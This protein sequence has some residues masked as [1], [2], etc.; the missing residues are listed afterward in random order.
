MNTD[1]NQPSILT[2]RLGQSD[3][4][5]QVRSN[6]GVSVSCLLT[7]LATAATIDTILDISQR[8][9]RWPEAC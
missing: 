4:A 6:L 8:M 3:Q 2:F 5:G 1:I 7:L 9:T